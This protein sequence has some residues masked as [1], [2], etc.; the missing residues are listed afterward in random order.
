[1]VSAC[2]GGSTSL[3]VDVRSDFV[4]GV[5]AVEVDVVVETIP[6]GT[7]TRRT[8][9]AGDDLIRGVRAAEIGPVPSGAHVI[10]A[11]LK[12]RGGEEL[13]SRRV[14]VEAHGVTGVVIA[15][16]RNCSG[17]TCPAVGGDPTATECQDGLCVPPACSGDACRSAECTVDTE[18]AVPASVCAQARCVEGVCLTASRIGACDAGFVCVEGSGC[19]AVS[20]PDAGTSDASMPDAGCTGACTP[21]QREDTACGTC[22][23]HR[24]V[25]ASD[26]TWGSYTS[27]TDDD[28]RCTD[29]AAPE[30]VN[31]YCWGWTPQDQ[32]A[33]SCVDMNRDY[34][35]SSTFGRLAEDVVGRPGAT[36]SKENR[37]VSCSGSSFATAP[38]EGGTLDTAGAGHFQAD[39]G[40]S[41]CDLSV[42][43][44][45]QSRIRF[46]DT[47]GS[48]FTLASVNETTF[49]NASCS[50]DRRSCSAAA[51]FCPPPACTGAC[52]AGEMQ[53]S[54]CGVCGTQT[55]TCASDCSWGSYSACTDTD[56][57][58]TGSTDECINDYCWGYRLVSQSLLSC[59]DMGRDYDSTSANYGT[60]GEDIFGRPGATWTKEN[61]ETSCA[62]SSYADSETGTIAPT[63]SD[64]YRVPYGASTCTNTILGHWRSRFRVRDTDGSSF[65]LSG[66]PEVTFRNSTCTADRSSCSAAASLCL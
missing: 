13:L 63:G 19:V 21:G 59:I 35:S 58:C 66:T 23:T 50:A 17:V 28:A 16:T 56:A 60:L 41:A 53:T 36:W 61:Q 65:Y 40:A 12:G 46:T 39:Y 37:Q 27:C 4:A 9:N 32:S 8:L 52:S 2:S 51:S 29:G 25:C 62:V 57:R 34:T 45:W 42:L 14:A 43:G 11:T 55:R 48:S 7:E 5:E 49:Y 64:S 15:L 24:R 20:T 22:G 31:D 54:N 44:R 26:C 18:C 47:D 30:C 3:V 38:S 33:L 1:L 6:G 10:R